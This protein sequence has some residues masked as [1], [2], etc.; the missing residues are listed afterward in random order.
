MKQ[1]SAFSVSTASIQAYVQVLIKLSGDRSVI[2]EWASK[3]LGT[4]DCHFGERLTPSGVCTEQIEACVMPVIMSLTE[5]ETKKQRKSFP[6]PTPTQFDRFLF[7]VGELVQVASQY[8]PVALINVVQT[9]VAPSFTSFELSVPNADGVVSPNMVK[10][11]ASTRAHAFLVLG[12]LCLTD[13]ALATKCITAFAHELESS[14]FPVVRNNVMVIMY[15][16][17]PRV[18]RNR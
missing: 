1:L 17:I 8:I 2:Q 6:V 4:R 3:L 12:K 18:H 9:L 10:V 15:A 7:T 13:Q 11:P 5:E 16:L 14:P